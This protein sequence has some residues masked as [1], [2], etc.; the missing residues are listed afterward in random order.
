MKLLYNL[1][2]YKDVNFGNYNIKLSIFI[3]TE[4]TKYSIILYIY[5]K[6]LDSY[7]IKQFDNES[8]CVKFLESKIDRKL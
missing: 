7:Y 2:Q 1:E 3:L 6:I 4:S 8:K 5:D